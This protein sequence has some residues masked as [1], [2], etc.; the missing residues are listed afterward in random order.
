LDGNSM[1]PHRSYVTPDITDVHPKLS[2]IPFGPLA[3]CA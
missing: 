1:L 3:V 2:G